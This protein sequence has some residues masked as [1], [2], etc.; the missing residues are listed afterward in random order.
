MT[1]HWLTSLG[2]LSP[3]QQPRI[4]TP[5]IMYVRMSKLNV[6]TGS[7]GTPMK[8]NVPRVGRALKPASIT[9]CT[10]V[11]VV[12]YDQSFQVRAKKDRRLTVDDHSRPNSISDL[13][14]SRRHVAH[15]GR[16]NAVGSA[17]RFRKID[18]RLD[19]VDRDDLFTA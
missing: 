10:P 14:E 2:T 4:L 19:F 16:V 11:A 1:C 8:M 15:T 6:A 3:S 12:Q 17:K 18:A 7:L 13:L 5:L 9:G